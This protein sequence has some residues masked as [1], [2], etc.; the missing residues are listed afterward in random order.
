MNKGLEHI[1]EELD[2]LSRASDVLYDYVRGLVDL[3][4]DD[5]N[6]S[7]R[8]INELE[9]DY[10]YSDDEEDDESDNEPFADEVEI[11]IATEEPDS[12][13]DDPFEIGEEPID[14][15]SDF[16]DICATIHKLVNRIDSGNLTGIETI[17]NRVREG[18]LDSSVEDGLAQFEL[19]SD[20][21]IEAL[22]FI[23]KGVDRSNP[24]S[25]PLLPP[26]ELIREIDDA[27]MQLFA[28]NPELL[29]RINPRMFEELI[30]EMF[31]KFNMSVT[32]TKKTR[33]GG[34]DIIAVEENAVARNRY[35]IEC[36]RYAPTKKVSIDVV[37]RLYG[38][39]TSQ[40]STKAF[41]VTSSYFSKDAL[42]FAK[43]HFWELELKDYDHIV[44]WLRLFW[45]RNS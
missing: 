30:A 43:Q 14:L 45:R 44:E 36:K 38:I 8:P 7:E 42:A 25:A 41:L 1:Q 26:P 10:Y 35:I 32:L 5:E 13:I 34:V 21:L 17:A 12:H 22:D 28:H 31:R 40:Q 37:Q 16:D 3:P 18:L 19:D 27:T 2:Y 29:Y 11:E 23:M 33:D 4:D 9:E 24:F 20:R 39:K 6:K 15:K